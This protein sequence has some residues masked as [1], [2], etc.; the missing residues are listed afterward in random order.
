MTVK[1]ITVAFY[2]RTFPRDDWGYDLNEKDFKTFVENIEAEFSPLG[3]AVRFEQLSDP[4]MEI[5]GYGD[6]L[7]SVRLRAPLCGIGNLCLG[8]VIG[9]SSN[10]DLFEDIKRGLNR[11][12]FA[13]ETIE[14][15]GSDKVVCH[16]CGCGC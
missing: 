1:E 11:V 14:P 13:P 3:I 5:R 6:I 9:S 4:V 12:A 7:N 10:R 15:D 2:A 16:N 8:H